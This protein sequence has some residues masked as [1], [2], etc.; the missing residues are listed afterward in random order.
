MQLEVL[1]RDLS[2]GQASA[3]CAYLDALSPRQRRELSGT[4]DRLAILAESDV[5]RWLE[6]CSSDSGGRAGA[7]FDL[8]DVVAER[9]VAYFRLDA[10]RRPLAAQMLGAALVQ[11][12]L[13][14]AA[15]RQHDPLP[16]LAV[17]DEF[18]ALGSDQVARL[19][20]R[21]R[22]AGISIVLGT[23]E[24]SDLRAAGA[25]L[26]EQVLGNVGAL[27]AH[28]QVVPDS[29]DLV[30]GV[31]GTHGAWVASERTERRLGSRVG[32]GA[33]RA[34]VREYLIHPDQIKTLPVGCAA[35]IVP[36]GRRQ[37]CIARIRAE[38]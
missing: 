20:G 19:F 13:T 6:P 15:Q 35:V 4:R 33:T 28:R 25:G 31:A 5:G 7:A 12:L 26:L 24:L 17:I 36:A 34:R 18:S 30:A 2:E 16:T 9:A 27:I 14:T 37:V 21:A 3:L 38:A 1:A 29:A 32:S 22:S 23:Q 11:D 8:L 10:D